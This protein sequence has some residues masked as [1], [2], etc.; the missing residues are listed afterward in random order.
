[1]SD[2]AIKLTATD[3]VTPVFQRIGKAAEATSGDVD[4]VRRVM[5]SLERE[6]AQATK[7]LEAAARG[8]DRTDREAKGLKGTLSDLKVGLAVL[9]AN[10]VM[11][12]RAAVDQ[13][14]QIA[15]LSRQYG[16]A[17]DELLQFA[18]DLQRT[19]SFSNDAA[20][21]AAASFATL[22]QNYGFTTEQIKTLIKVSA[23]L[24]A[25]KGI[26]LVS[27]AERIQAAMRGEAES[28]E[29][30]GLT[31]NDTAL[32]IDRM[33]KSTTDAEKGQIRFQALLRQAAY[34]QGLAA[35]RA[36]TAAGRTQ[37]LMNRVQDL[38]QEFAAATGPAGQM[39][40]ALSQQALQVGLATAGITQLVSGI[41]AA[42][43][44]LTG[45]VTALGPAGLVLAAGA[46]VAGV[47]ALADALT[48]SYGEAAA[49]AQKA[50]DDLAQSI[51]QLAEAADP[52][53]L[54]GTSW[55]AQF[56]AAFA[57]FDNLGQ[58][59][60]DLNTQ[61]LD[62]QQRRLG[63]TSTEEL[64]AIDRQIAAVEE[65]ISQIEQLIDVFGD[66]KTAE[67][68][69]AETL[70]ALNAILN[71]T[72]PA[73]AGARDAVSRLF[74]MFQEGR[75]TLPQ[76][77]QAIQD[78]AQTLPDLNRMATSSAEGIKKIGQE[79]TVSA[80]AIEAYGKALSSLTEPA[81]ENQ[82]VLDAIAHIL[83]ASVPHADGYREALLATWHAYQ[84]GKISLEQFE[85]A[86]LGL[87][88]A[89]RR[90]EIHLQAVT[91]QLYATVA[92]HRAGEQAVE[93][94][95]RGYDLL[96]DGSARAR[97]AE[98]DWAAEQEKVNAFIKQ[99]IDAYVQARLQLREYANELG[100]LNTVAQALRP[101]DLPV[102]GADKA[103]GLA[104]EM[105]GRT[106]ALDAV[107]R[108][109]AQV[110]QLQRRGEDAVEIAKNLVG[111]PGVY[112]EID[113]MLA[114]G[115]I[116]QKRYNMAVEAGYRIQ[117]RQAEI[118]EN[119]NR[120]R[121]KQLPLL[122]EA[123]EQYTELIADISR[124]DAKQQMITLGFMDATESMK[125]QQA[126]MLAT[127]AAYGELGAAGEETATRIIQG[128]VAADPVLK[129]MLEDLGLISVGADG[130]VTVNFPEGESINELLDKTNRNLEDLAIAIDLIDGKPDLE[131]TV[132][133]LENE[134]RQK[135]A[136][137]KKAMDDLDGTTAS[138][139]VVANTTPFW[140]AVNA[141]DGSY[142]GTVYVGVENVRGLGGF[143]PYATGGT[144]THEPAYP[145]FPHAAVGM[146]SSGTMAVVGEAGRELVHLPAGAQVLAH[147]ATE[148]RLRR[149]S[150]GSGDVVITGPVTVVANDPVAFGRELAKYR[151]SEVRR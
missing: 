91:N 110:D 45:F 43:P 94:H 5:D 136:Q 88:E 123:H 86:V 1:M 60:E 105:Q 133:Y 78:I 25:A 10:F 111:E 46:A 71:D 40:A 84:D 140:T 75:I 148:S 64:E 147:P 101:F 79:A 144:V 134:A 70:S 37:Q 17:A 109:Y 21:E 126:V 28:A 145:S 137:T 16:A 138:V 106:E 52:R 44:A 67:R 82:K 120:I 131:I 77:M 127:Q 12:S 19:T 68:E 81:A 36:E 83:K 13:E 29:F 34:A 73:A 99:Q 63:V 8:L 30:L 41:R 62:L 9:G 146:T 90:E 108:I 24:A 121:A 51:R 132:K 100:V 47:I 32:G 3:G 61:L 57:P 149:M 125:A 76:L 117:Q 103:I 130:T 15:V 142:V 53:S 151:R 58:K 107:L 22:A 119:L 65:Q 92:A 20:R 87:N 66:A 115:F 55:Q 54:L 96:R 33:S 89:L 2:V 98:A 49:R 118:E 11:A 93:D 48:E 80:K 26:D 6:S 114:K 129:A 113:D 59:L 74:Q 69:Q 143:Q 139:S 122:D 141:I 85:R 50:S 102:V 38:A 150:R 104:A 7:A 4:G 14:R 124:M 23:D 116:S 39:A 35:E 18:E 42:T 72:G 128:A 95:A 112:A 97:Q 31:L 56:E 135:I 27:A